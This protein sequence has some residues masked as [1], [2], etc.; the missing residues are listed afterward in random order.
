MPYFLISN[1][2][3]NIDGSLQKVSL[4]STRPAIIVIILWMLSRNVYSGGIYST[5]VKLG[6]SKEKEFT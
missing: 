6:T 3:L 2:F 5:V 4:M 1:P